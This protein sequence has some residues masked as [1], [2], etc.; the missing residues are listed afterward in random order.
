MLSD[1]E[2]ARLDDPQLVGH[3]LIQYGCPE[4][5]RAVERLIGCTMLGKG[6]PLE[7]WHWLNAAMLT[8]AQRAVEDELEEENTRMQR[9]GDDG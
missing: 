4:T 1:E 8:A 3:D 5:Q 6:I 2:R 7:T 9:E